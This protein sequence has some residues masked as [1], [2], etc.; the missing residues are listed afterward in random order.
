MFFEDSENANA[1][2]KNEITVRKKIVV[3]F[4]EQQAQSMFSLFFISKSMQQ[5]YKNCIGLE[6]RLGMIRCLF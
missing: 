5:F 1:R 4:F 6:R 2:Q 3:F